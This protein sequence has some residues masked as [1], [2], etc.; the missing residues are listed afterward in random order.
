[1]VHQTNEVTALSCKAVACS[2]I[3]GKDSLSYSVFAYSTSG[4]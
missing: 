1:M 4:S 2:V 3:K